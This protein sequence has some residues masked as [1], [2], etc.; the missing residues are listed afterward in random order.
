MLCCPCMNKAPVDARLRASCRLGA[1]RRD[2]HAVEAGGLAGNGTQG[3]GLPGIRPLGPCILSLGC[4]PVSVI[5]SFPGCRT[6][7]AR[8]VHSPVLDIA[9]EGHA[10]YSV[11]IQVYQ[12]RTHARTHALTLTLPTLTPILALVHVQALSF[13]L[14]LSPLA[15][16]HARVTQPTTHLPHPPSQP[17]PVHERI[18]PSHTTPVPQLPVRIMR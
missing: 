6:R 11:N 4:S 1:L 9:T 18:P 7:T 15:L 5:S 8:L 10:A 13:S 3:G 17:Q 14:S 2:E 16:A 12:A